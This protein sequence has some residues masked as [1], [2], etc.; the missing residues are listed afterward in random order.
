MEENILSISRSLFFQI[1]LRDYFCQVYVCFKTAE[2]AAEGE[3][4]KMS[5]TF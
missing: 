2:G 4:L 3:L 5:L 1:S